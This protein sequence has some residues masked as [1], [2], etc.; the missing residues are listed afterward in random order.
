MFD[1]SEAGRWMRQASYT[2]DSANLDANG[3]FYS[4]ACFKS[5]QAAEYSLKAL[6]RG[7]GAESFGHDLITLWREAK[8]LS[9]RIWR[10]SG[11]V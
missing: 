4:W 10:A 2:I 9:V 11:T 8:D 3:G 6:L 1:C 5:H 7:F